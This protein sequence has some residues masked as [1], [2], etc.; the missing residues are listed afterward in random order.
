M[1][2]ML[3]SL[4]WGR[5]D[6]TSNQKGASGR[7]TQLGSK[8]L[9]LAPLPPTA[10]PTPCFTYPIAPPGPYLLDNGYVALVGFH[11]YVMLSTYPIYDLRYLALILHLHGTHA[12]KCG[13]PALHVLDPEYGIC[14]VV[15][16]I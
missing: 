9:L 10:P 12:L 13:V 6:D 8:I 2:P 16:Q 15:A 1:R 11:Y 7:G 3:Q 14:A 4:L 5:L